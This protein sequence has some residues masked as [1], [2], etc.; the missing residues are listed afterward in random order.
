MVNWAREE[1][2]ERGAL[3]R[4]LPSMVTMRSRGSL[5]LRPRKLDLTSP[6]AAAWA[7]LAWRSRAVA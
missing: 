7:I 1:V 3:S 2:A 5:D 6:S 4:T